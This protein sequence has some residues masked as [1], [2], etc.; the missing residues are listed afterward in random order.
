LLCKLDNSQI[1]SLSS[2]LWKF[3]TRLELWTLARYIPLLHSKIKTYCRNNGP[4]FWSSKASLKALF[5]QC[6]AV[7]TFS[8]LLVATETCTNEGRRHS[9]KENLAWKGIRIQIKSIKSQANTSQFFEIEW[10]SYCTSCVRAYTSPTLIVSKH[11]SHLPVHNT[12][13]ARNVSR[14]ADAYEEWFCPKGI[15][16]T[17]SII[18]CILNCLIF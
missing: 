1:T 6:F 11:K 3:S 10:K 8:V 9:L 7:K 18:C 12:F 5:L 17:R 14:I 15:Q 16:P 4:V 13:C 2:H